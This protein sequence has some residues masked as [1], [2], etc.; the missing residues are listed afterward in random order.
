M[1][2][3]FILSI[4][5]LPRPTLTFLQSI[6]K[7]ATWFCLQFVLDWVLW[8]GYAKTWF[9]RVEWEEGRGLKEIGR[10]FRQRLFW[11]SLSLWQEMPGVFQLGL[12]YLW[13]APT[14][15]CPDG[16]QW[17]GWTGFC[18]AYYDCKMHLS[19]NHH[20][21]LKNQGLLL[22]DPRGCAAHPE[23]HNKVVGKERER[24]RE[25]RPGVLPLLGSRVVWPRVSKIH[26]LLAN[27]KY[28]SG[29]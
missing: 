9:N 11:V 14:G 2:G 1:P 4:S 15:N 23:P 26:S 24:E 6:L 19:N 20:G 21:T 12:Y 3:S 18:G 10:T 17:C 7:M 5:D 8:G 28:K 16:S 22:R 25:H 27:L 29:N 13:W